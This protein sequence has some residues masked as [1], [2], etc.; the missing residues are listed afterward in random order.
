[1]DMFRK[2]AHMNLTISIPE[3]NLCPCQLF[4]AAASHGL[5]PPPEDYLIFGQVKSKGGITAQM[6]IRKEKYQLTFAKRPLKHS[7]CI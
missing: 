6:L 2:A 1:M 7:L 3:H 4:P 5:T